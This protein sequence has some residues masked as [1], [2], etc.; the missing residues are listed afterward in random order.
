MTFSPGK[1]GLNARYPIYILGPS[2][3]LLNIQK[4][5][6]MINNFK[7]ISLNNENAWLLDKNN[8]LN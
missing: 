8:S 7:S 5:K 4:P 3:C 2:H 6:Q 1:N